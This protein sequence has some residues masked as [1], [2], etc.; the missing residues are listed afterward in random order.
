MGRRDG[1]RSAQFEHTL[2]ITETGVEAFTGRLPTSNPFFWELDGKP[3]YTGVQGSAPVSSTVSA[4]VS[5]AAPDFGL[6]RLTCNMPE[7]L[8]RY[9]EIEMVCIRKRGATWRCANRD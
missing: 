7:I 5:S 4:A 9:R 3:S 6:F 1:K 8:L 2:L